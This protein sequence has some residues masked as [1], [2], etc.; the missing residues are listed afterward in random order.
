MKPA[1]TDRNQQ[2]FLVSR[3][4]SLDQGQTAYNAEKGKS[5]H[6]YGMNYTMCNVYTGEGGERKQTS[7]K[8]IFRAP[9]RRIDEPEQIQIWAKIHPKK[10]NITILMR[11]GQEEKI[12]VKL[13]EEQVVVVLEIS[14]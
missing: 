10:N 8:N 11:D 1:A 9:K 7:Q 12:G 5:F 6:L 14:L 3:K 4:R 2:K 13:T